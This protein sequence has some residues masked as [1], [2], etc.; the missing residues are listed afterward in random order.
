MYFIHII[1]NVKVRVEYLLL[2]R[3]KTVR[4]IWIKFL[5]NTYIS[6]KNIDHV[7]FTK[8]YCNEAGCRVLLVLQRITAIFFI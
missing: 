7:G 1:M 8:N 6:K 4:P 5:C 3:V 2:N